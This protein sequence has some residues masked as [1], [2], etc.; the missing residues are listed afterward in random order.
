MADVVAE[1]TN[2][3]VEQSPVG[4]MDRKVRALPVIAFAVLMV[5]VAGIVLLGRNSPRTNH[6]QMPAVPTERRVNEP[7]PVRD[8]DHYVPGSPPAVAERFLRAWMH[9]HYDEAR[10]LATGEMRVR[11]E[12][13]MAEVSAFNAQQMEEYRHTRPY[14]DATNVDLEHVEMRDLPPSADGHP[15]KEV[16]GQG[17]AYGSFNDNG[18]QMDSR[19]GQTF[20]LEMV[21]GAW[22]VA[23]RS[24]ETF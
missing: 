22:R 5:S 9:A 13:E 1:Q 2:E 7:T 17:H 19:R 8:V 6:A 11:A 18:T 3:P 4:G 12:R 14:L 23:E 15:R 10:D 16:R 24:W 20:V 21:D